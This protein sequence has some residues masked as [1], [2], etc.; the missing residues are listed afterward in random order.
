MAFVP[1]SG[2]KR[3]EELAE[4]HGPEAPIVVIPAK[5]SWHCGHVF[6]VFIID[7]E[8]VVVVIRVDG[9]LQLNGTR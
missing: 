4:Q 8:V 9:V 7:E 3:W 5:R 2:W 1:I 6:D